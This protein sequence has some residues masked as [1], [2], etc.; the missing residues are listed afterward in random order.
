M[1]LETG[2]FCTGQ[3]QATIYII[4]GFFSIRKPSKYIIYEDEYLFTVYI[5]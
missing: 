1:V 3:T 2:A 5:F 4:G